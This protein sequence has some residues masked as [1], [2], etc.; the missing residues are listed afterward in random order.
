MIGLH[1]LEDV[2]HMWWQLGKERMAVCANGRDDHGRDDQHVRHDWHLHRV[3]H[4]G[5]Q[6]HCNGYALHDDKHCSDLRES[7]VQATDDEGADVRNVT[8][9]ERHQTSQEGRASQKQHVAQPAQNQSSD[10]QQVCQ[11]QRVIDVGVDQPLTTN[12]V[13]CRHDKCR[14]CQALGDCPEEQPDT[15]DRRFVGCVVL[16]GGVEFRLG[17]GLL[18]GDSWCA[19]GLS[20]VG[21][22]LSHKDLEEYQDADVSKTCRSSRDAIGHF[23]GDR[24]VL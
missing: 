20:L 3:R 17:L 6:P 9:K 12:G 22:D 1:V 5:Q 15:T 10:N 11:L 14:R 7:D 24:E 18:G 21:R 23:V 4:L 2:L 19:G 13:Q 8:Q 16:F